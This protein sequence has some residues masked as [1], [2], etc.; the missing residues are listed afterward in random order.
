MYRPDGSHRPTEYIYQRLRAVD[1]LS[2][3]DAK[4]VVVTNKDGESKLYSEAG[5][6]YDLQSGWVVLDSG[7]EASM[8]AADKAAA[9]IGVDDLQIGGHLSELLACMAMRDVERTSSRV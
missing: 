9:R 4:E 7:G 6:R 1:G 2:V 3:S 8:E 5:L